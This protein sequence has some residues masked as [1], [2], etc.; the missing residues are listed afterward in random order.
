MRYWKDFPNTTE[1]TQ[2]YVRDNAG[3]TRDIYWTAGRYSQEGKAQWEWATTK[4]YQQLVYKNWYPINPVQPDFNEPGYCMN[5]SFAT[6]GYWFDTLC[7]NN[8][9]FIC[10]SN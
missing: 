6:P 2:L 10:E 1:K 7:T 5:I 3:I 4:P 9:K 8:I